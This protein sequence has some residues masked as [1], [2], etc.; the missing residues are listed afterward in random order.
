MIRDGD[1]LIQALALGREASRVKRFHTVNTIK[2]N[3]VGQHSFNVIGML[4]VCIPPTAL[5]SQLLAAAWQHDVPEARVGDVPSPF[6]RE[7]RKE[8]VNIEAIE[9]RVLEDHGMHEMGRYLYDH[10]V[11]WLKMA[12]I[13]EGWLFCLDEM[14]MGNRWARTASANFANYAAE[15]MERLLE[16]N[17]SDVVSAEDNSAVLDNFNNV[18]EYLAIGQTAFNQEVP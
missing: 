9:R 5:R 7:L 11:G 3:T 4:L 8:G 15:Q 2:E 1:K 6:K 10:E 12:D 13:L 16:M 18:A 17:V 14:S